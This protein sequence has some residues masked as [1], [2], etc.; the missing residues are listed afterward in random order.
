MNTKKSKT[1]PPKQLPATGF[2]RIKMLLE[3]IPFSTSTLWRKVKSGDF[4]APIKLSSNITAFKAEEV[5]AWME[6][7]K[8]TA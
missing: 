7:I 2:I 8:N 4:P 3:F 1:L 6:E 5:H